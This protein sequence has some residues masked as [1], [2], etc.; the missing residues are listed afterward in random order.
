VTK[1]QVKRTCARHDRTAFGK[2]FLRND[3]MLKMPP[4][5]KKTGHSKQFISDKA[6]G[7]ALCGELPPLWLC[8]GKWQRNHPIV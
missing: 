2:T 5:L 6:F 7:S 8:P 4:V 1:S 3:G